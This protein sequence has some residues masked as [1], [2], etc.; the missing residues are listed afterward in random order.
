MPEKTPKKPHTPNELVGDVVRLYRRDGR[1]Y[2]NAQI[3]GKQRRVSLKTR[4]KRQAHR[5]AVELEANILAGRYRQR[6]PVPAAADVLDMYFDTRVVAKRSAK[7]LRKYEGYL[8]KFKEF[9]LKIGVEKITDITVAV[10]DKYR[11]AR[12]QDG[13]DDTTVHLELVFLRS[14]VNYALSRGLIL[15]DPLKGLRLPKAETPEQPYWTPEELI[16]ANSDGVYRL[17]FI[18]F[19]ETGMRAGEVLHLEWDDVDEPR[20]VVH[21][22]VKDDWTPKN[23]K[24]RSVA[25]TPRM[26]DAFAALRVDAVGKWV[27]R[28]RRSVRNPVGD[29]QLSMD[30]LRYHLGKVLV[31]LTMEGKLHSFRHS[32]VSHAL[33][34]DNPVPEAVL[35]QIVGQVDK[36]IVKRYTHIADRIARESMQRLAAAKVK[37]AA[38]V[39]I[40]GKNPPASEAG[41]AQN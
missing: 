31:K 12:F 10:V 11:A 35:Q 38:D 15:V 27:F 17:A 16:I 23:K 20:G 28:T 25:I 1:Y 24:S 37:V 14:A 6:K 33:T 22:R 32:F 2:A 7:T 39:V 34:S 40:D 18:V 4:D 3:N 9:F 13:A 8:K 29:R 36:K 21:I 19:W 30:T 26:A 5:R 41:T